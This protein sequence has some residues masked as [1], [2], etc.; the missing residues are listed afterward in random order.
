MKMINQKIT[1]EEAKKL[2]EENKITVNDEIM[3]LLGIIEKPKPKEKKKKKNKNQI[4]LNQ[5][6]GNIQMITLIIL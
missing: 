6:I 3:D 1:K 2:V 4:T 5:K